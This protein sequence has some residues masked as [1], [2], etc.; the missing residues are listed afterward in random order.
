MMGFLQSGMTVCIESYIGA[1][2][3]R[4]GVKLEDQVLVTE[5]DCEILSRYPFEAELLK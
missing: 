2:G 1:I 5:T 3:Q 4:E